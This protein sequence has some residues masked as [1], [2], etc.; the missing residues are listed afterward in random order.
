MKARRAGSEVM[1]T[2]REHKC[3]PKLLYTA[4]LSTNIDGETK[5]FQDKTKFKQYLSI[6]SALHRILKGK[7]LHKEGTCTKEKTKC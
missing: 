6:N 3:P 4:K 1:Q 5:R 7:L 2:I